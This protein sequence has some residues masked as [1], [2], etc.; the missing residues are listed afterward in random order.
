M[1]G[2]DSTKNIL[3]KRKQA[4]ANKD[5]KLSDELRNKIKTLG[6]EILDNKSGQEIKK[7]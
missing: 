2:K 1:L 4:R 3:K 5:F 7:I 6:F